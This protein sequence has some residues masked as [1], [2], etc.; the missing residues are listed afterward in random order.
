VRRTE[1]SR[2]QVLQR[3]VAGLGYLPSWASP[4]VLVT[5]REARDGQLPPVELSAVPQPATRRVLARVLAR[6]FAVA[7]ALDLWPAVPALR[8]SGP[9]KSYHFGGSFP[10]VAGRPRAER[11]ETDVLG[12]PAEWRRIHL[13]DASVFQS[14]AAT[15]FTL[16][17]MA[18]AHRIATLV[19]RELT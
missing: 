17:V 4:A 19:A 5:V 7:P 3:V 18:N 11:L 2:R 14:V 13:I 10:H 6:L 1:F 12:R 8:L 9:G 16:T 15:T